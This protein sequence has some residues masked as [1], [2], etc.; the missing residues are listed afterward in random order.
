MRITLGERGM[1]EGNVEVKLRTAKEK[2]LV[3]LDEVVNYLRENF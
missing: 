2:E 3:G 1:Q